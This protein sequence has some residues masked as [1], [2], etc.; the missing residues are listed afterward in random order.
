M[1]C[2]T[3]NFGTKSYDISLY[4]RINQANF[5]MII[6]NLIYA[7]AYFIILYTICFSP[8]L[9]Y[10]FVDLDFKSKAAP[11]EAIK[12]LSDII[13]NSNYYEFIQ[14]FL[15]KYCLNVISY[16][17][18]RL[19]VYHTIFFLSRTTDILFVKILENIFIEFYNIPFFPIY[20]PLK[21]FLMYCGYAFQCIFKNSV[22]KF[23][24]IILNM[25]SLVVTLLPG[26]VMYSCFVHDSK[27][28]IFMQI[29]L[30]I[31]TVFNMWICGRALND[32]IPS[33]K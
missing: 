33:S 11:L 25:I 29:P 30:F 16:C 23:C 2:L 12:D 24:E 28:I 3:F 10:V 7:F 1:K 4:E 31:Y 18:T 32:I 14:I 27:R 5:I 17:F 21:Y 22:G 8:S 6:L 13:Y 9:Y 19:I 20:F 26:C 15:G